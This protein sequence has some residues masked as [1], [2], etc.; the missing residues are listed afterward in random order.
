RTG[1]LVAID[2][3]LVEVAARADS[4]EL[5][6]EL[7]EF[8]RLA[9]GKIVQR[10]VT[11]DVVVVGLLLHEAHEAADVGAVYTLF[12]RLPDGFGHDIPVN[13]VRSARPDRRPV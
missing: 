6:D 10:R 4:A 3:D 7:P 8:F 12:A 13:G 11:A 9:H 2:Q 5:P 1:H